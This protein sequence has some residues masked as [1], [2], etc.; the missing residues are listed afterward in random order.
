MIKYLCFL[1]LSG[2]AMVLELMNCMLNEGVNW[3]SGGCLTARLMRL[4]LSGSSMSISDAKVKR[5]RLGVR[6]LREIR[7]SFFLLNATIC[8]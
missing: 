7:V 2:V 3:I 6:D 4:T 5:L 1:A 8:R